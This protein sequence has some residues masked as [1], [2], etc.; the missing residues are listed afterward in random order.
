MYPYVI[1]FSG[2]AM[3]ADP[4][5]RAFTVYEHRAIAGTQITWEQPSKIL[6]MDPTVANAILRIERDFEEALLLLQPRASHLPSRLRSLLWI[7]CSLP[8]LAE[9]GMPIA[10]EGD[11]R[12]QFDARLPQ[13]H[14]PPAMASAATA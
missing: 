14:R 5:L 8:V 6:P 4:E 2:A 9:H 3:A 7:L 11:V 10:D 12:A 13:L 1:P